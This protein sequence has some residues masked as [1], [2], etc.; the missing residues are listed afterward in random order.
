MARW[1]KLEADMPDHPKTGRLAELLKDPKAGWYVVRAL[2]WLSRFC[3]A[4]Q[5]SDADGTTLERACEWTGD[6]GEL[7]AAFVACGW[8]DIA[9]KGGWTWHDWDDHQGKVAY[10][11][12]KERERKAA[13]RA[14]QADA[15]PQNVPRDNDGTSAGRPRDVRPNETRRDETRRDETGSKDPGKPGS[16]K[17]PTEKQAALLE[18][19]P[20]PTAFVAVPD[21]RHAPL[22]A[23]LVQAFE[24]LRKARYPFNG[25]DAKAV[26]EL[27]KT[28][29]EPAALVQAWRRSLVSD[30]PK[31]STLSELKTN[32]AHFVGQ[33]AGSTTKG[34]WRANVDHAKS[35]GVE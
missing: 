17:R 7:V 30:F 35:W 31:V 15:S 22:V 32:L 8:L 6:S 18:V 19:P 9:R 16:A 33:G 12:T 4:G 23:D 27:L 14:R 20:D 13:Y 25:R 34:D 3:P 2:A 26:S 10:R 28:G 29:T 24:D 1:F 21:P 11:A 5:I